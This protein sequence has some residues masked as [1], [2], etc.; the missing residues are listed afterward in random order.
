M[1]VNLG[2]WI[3]NTK[4]RRDKLTPEQR[5]TLAELGVDWA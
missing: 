2:V 4:S 5:T 1:T 3:S